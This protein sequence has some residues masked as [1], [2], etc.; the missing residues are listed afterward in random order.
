MGVLGRVTPLARIGVATQDSDGAVDL[1]GEHGAREF[2]G[3][4]HLRQRQ[5]RGI[6]GVV[7]PGERQSVGSADYEDDVAGV[8]FR[9]A[10]ELREFFTRYRAAEWVEQ[11][12][13]GVRMP[14]PG[15]E[16]AGMDFPHFAFDVSRGSFDELIGNRVGVIVALLA[17]VV[18]MHFHAIR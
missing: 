5:K 10:Y 15:I 6:G 14:L 3:E 7:T 1:L 12:L 8:E 11:D 2:M 18:E 17:D 9:V 13:A 4:R 16:A